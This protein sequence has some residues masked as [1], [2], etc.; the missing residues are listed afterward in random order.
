MR[1]MVLACDYDGTLA[2]HGRVD[3]ATV[4]ALERC[5]ES[6]RKLVLVTGRE[7]PE[8]QGIFPQLSLFDWVVAENGG[9]LFRP[10][11][12]TETPLA[13]APSEEFVATLRKRG[14]DRVSTGRVI[15]AT[16]EPHETTVLE[17]IRDLGLELQVVFN[18]GAVMVLPSGI[19]KA[20]GLKAAL[21]EMGFSLHNVVGVGDAENDHALL[22]GCEAG[23]A[24]ANAVATL[25]EHADWVTPSD[26]GAGVA[27]LISRM[28]ENDLADLEPRLKRH[29]ILLGQT[30]DDQS[31]YI[32]PF[33]SN[34]LIA[35]S[36]GGGKST[37]AT[38][39]VERLT[40]CGY[41][42]CI[43]DPEG[44]YDEFEHAVSIGTSRQPPMI[45]AV[46]KMLEPPD[47]SAVVNLL[48][49][50]LQDRPA[51]FLSLLGRLQEIRARLG[52]PHWIAIDEAHHVW[53]TTWEPAGLVRAEMLDRIQFITLEPRL[54]P[55]SALASVDLVLAIGKSPGATLRD[56]AEAVRVPAPPEQ[57]SDLEHGT[58]VAWQVQPYGKPQLIKLAPTRSQRRR[59]VRK[60]AEGELEP[61]NSFYFRGP[62]QKLNLRAQNLMVFL[63]M[64]D[65]VDDDTWGYHLQAGDYSK[66][67]RDQI[68][69]P[70][71]ADEAA[72]VAADRKW[73]AQES[74]EQVRRLVEARYTLVAAPATPVSSRVTS[75]ASRGK[76][77]PGGASGAPAVA[78]D[79]CEPG[80]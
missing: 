16:W 32:E 51:F 22:S 78:E 24:V 20:T 19:N 11:T 73:T 80:R 77:V 44:D 41:Q 62:E 72:A 59:H 45:D 54:L 28:V 58:V 27:E 60:Y 70:E 79:H 64:A 61:E 65:G 5:I 48:G 4:H 50:P 25:K 3:Q 38:A 67:F 63:Q 52:R 14:V 1:F 9:L 33:R 23:V 18:K 43:I 37:A 7:L 68:K 69:D 40:D 47:Q 21:K 13:E 46:M 71:L 55:A 57:F 8:L 49:V 26:H 66:W 30:R 2:H 6:G 42:V 34:V 31:F 29:H 36:S 74:R 39:I 75:S 76:A 53:P 35:G 15:V 56:F 12:K 10:A 17:S